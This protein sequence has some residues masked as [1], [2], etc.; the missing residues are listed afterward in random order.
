[1]VPPFY[2]KPGFE[3]IYQYYSAISKAVNIPTKEDSS[4]VTLKP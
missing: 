2:S 1:M 4:N 3:E